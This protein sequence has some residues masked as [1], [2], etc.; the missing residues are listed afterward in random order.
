MLTQAALR[1]VRG[2]LRQT[3]WAE[4]GQRELRLGQLA[5]F[6]ALQKDKPLSDKRS[7]LKRRLKAEKKVAEKEAKQKELSEKQLSQATVAATNH[8]TDNDV[9]AEEESLDPNVGSMPK[10][11]LGESSSS[12]TFGE[13][14]SSYKSWP[15]PGT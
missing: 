14:E 6:T 12:M 2:S 5:P 15:I 10:E 9:G 3:S 1:L 11:L 8:T 4:W 13:R 7:E